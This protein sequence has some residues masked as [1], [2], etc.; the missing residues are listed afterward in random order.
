MVWKIF[1]GRLSIWNCNKRMKW[2]EEVLFIN[3]IFLLNSISLPNF[4][5]I[6][7]S[8][9]P[10]TITPSPLSA[11]S[12]TIY[13]LI[14]LFDF[15]TLFYNLSALSFHVPLFLAGA[16]ILNINSIFFYF[17]SLLHSSLIEITHPQ[18]IGFFNRVAH[19]DILWL[20]VWFKCWGS[21]EVSF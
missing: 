1:P 14:E 2:R 6:L 18:Y 15:V 4:H 11:A 20:A 12:S 19:L 7:C 8:V 21:E 5:N 17:L 13:N 16:T 9:V 3:L 10:T